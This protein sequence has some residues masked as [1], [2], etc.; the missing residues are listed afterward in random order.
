M[1]EA[2]SRFRCPACARL[3]LWRQRCI[4]CGHDDRDTAGEDDR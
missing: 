1:T 2:V 4:A 3:T